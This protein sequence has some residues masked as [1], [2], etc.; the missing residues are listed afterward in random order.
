MNYQVMPDLT[1]EDF[2]SLKADI[3][4]RG[5]LVPVEY[6]EDGN[7]LDGHHRVR[8]CTELGIKKWPKIARKG[9]SEDDKRLHARQL[10]LVRRHLS[11]AEKRELIAAQIKDTPE[12]SNRQ[13]AAKLGV[14]HPT[15][16]DVRNGLERKGDVE[17][18]TTSTDSLGRKQPAQKPKKP[19]V[20][21]QESA[22]FVP[23]EDMQAEAEVIARDLQIERDERIAISGTGHL[24]EENDRLT[25]LVATLQRRV[26]ALIKEKG[27]VE[28]REKMWKERA[29]AA[30]W[31]GHPDA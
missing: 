24:V 20:S 27:A 10:N 31:K 16:A 11:A 22:G 2:E 15:V 13:I 17:K 4:K 21:A 18:F 14:S 23:D 5:V 28:Y 8:A 12:S 7:I 6:D 30:G 19:E 1:A 26:A 3:A 9:L 25:K 29:L